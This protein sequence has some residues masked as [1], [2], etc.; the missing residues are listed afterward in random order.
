[1]IVPLRRLREAG[2][3]WL[4]LAERGMRNRGIHA[5]LASAS[6]AQHLGLLGCRG[7]GTAKQHMTAELGGAVPSFPAGTQH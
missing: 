5:Q 7:T 1:M 4:P 2:P 3:S 6:A